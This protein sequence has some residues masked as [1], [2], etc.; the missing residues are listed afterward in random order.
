M[1]GEKKM[2]YKLFEELST[3]N[4]NEIAEE[5]VKTIINDLENE[6]YRRKNAECRE[7]IENFRQAFT[8]LEDLGI[9]VLYDCSNYIDNDCDLT[10]ISLYNGHNLAFD[11]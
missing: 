9:T 5:D 6:L 1:K 2:A 10:C 11:Y 7:A 4:L 3:C 8:R